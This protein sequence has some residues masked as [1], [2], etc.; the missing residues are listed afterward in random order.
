MKTSTI[1]VL[2]VGG[3]HTAAALVTIGPSG[4]TVEGVHRHPLRA[5]GDVDD[6]IVDL[7]AASARLNAPVHATWGIAIPG[8]F[9]YD[10]GVGRFSGVGKFEAL[11]GVDLRH[12]LL[13]NIDP[14][15]LDIRFLNDADAFAIG[16]WSAGAAQGHRRVLALTLGTGVGSC[17]LRDGH[18]VHDDPGVPP[19]GYVY[20]LAIAGQPLEEVVSRRA[21]LNHYRRLQRN[22]PADLDVHDLAGLARGGDVAATRAIVEPLATLGRALRPWV[23]RFGA[24]G[25]VVGG[26]IA[27]S[28]D[29]V[30]PPIAETLGPSVT[31]ARAQMGDR[32]PLIGAAV[33]A[34]QQHTLQSI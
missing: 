15:P 23:Q 6:V 34:A 31:V 32:G 30:G 33:Y 18:P 12:I 14:P 16:E 22:A 24:S 10:R 13:D 20:R 1:P 25:V 19:D 17:F 9:D 26:S 21:I 28:W 7:V 29:L 2:E 27:N 8:P 4:P 5:D 3:T 11:Y